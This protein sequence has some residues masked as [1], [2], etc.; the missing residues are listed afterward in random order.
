MGPDYTN[1]PSFLSLNQKLV[2]RKRFSAP[3]PKSPDMGANDPERNAVLRPQQKIP[4]LDD[5]TL[6][7]NFNAIDF[8]ALRILL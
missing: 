5:K 2:E 7:E 6:R 1:S 3:P 8:H 4:K